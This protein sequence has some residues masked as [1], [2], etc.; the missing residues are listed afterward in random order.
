MS[1][2]D[3]GGVEWRPFRSALGPAV[4][5]AALVAG[6]LAGERAGAASATGAL[7]AGTVGL[8]AAW[9]VTGRTR[10]AVATLALALLGTATMQRAL[11]GLERSP[12]AAVAEGTEV[13]VR[14]T[15]V[16]DPAGPRF[17]ADALLRVDTFTPVDEP[18]D[19]QRVRRTVMVRAT[20]KEA[21]RLRVLAAGD[22]VT[23]TGRLGPLDGF[24]TR[25]RWHHAVARLDG[26]DVVAFASPRGQ[27]HAG[28][29]RLRS[30]ILRGIATLPTVERGLLGGFLLGDTRVVP[31]DV[32]ADFRASGLSHLLAV[33]GANVA[34]VLALAGPL[35]RRLP[36]AGRFAGGVA[37]VLVFATA[38]R[39]EPSVMRASALAAASLTANFAGRP[40]H[41]VRLLALAV[42]ALVLVDPFLVHSVAFTLSCGASAGIVLLSRPVGE[43]LRGPAWF[44]ESLA[45]TLAAQV[46]VTPVLIPVFGSMPAITPVAN[47]IAA[48]LAGPLT[49][50]G[51]VAGASGG[52]VGGV[53]PAV[54]AVLQWPSGALVHVIAL[55]AHHAAR[56]PF[57]IDGRGVLASVALTALASA[58]AKAGPALRGRRA[59][60]G[61][62]R[63]DARG[64][65]PDPASR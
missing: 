25:Y 29:N 33:S 65:L 4:G 21:G 28:A 2:V 3:V 14:G 38:T 18:A 52:L 49:V 53:L 61:S 9:F 64:A 43:W 19:V 36:L 5:L 26:A 40:A 57:G 44:R 62:L 39:Y 7:V 50:Y 63:S 12:L 31:D 13:E 10:L 42:T 17:R 46:G 27:L 37:V 23:L 35:L 56:V 51:L 41:P 32:I 54:A 22:H 20:G 58:L 15:L 47:L 30:V 8:A 24:D 16:T 1:G 11:D 59:T 48:P 45:V 6:V 60:G 34:F 55:V